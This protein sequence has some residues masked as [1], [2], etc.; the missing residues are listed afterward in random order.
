M[1]T[2]NDRPEISVRIGKQEIPLQSRTAA[3]VGLVARHQAAINSAS[4]VKVVLD[5]S[6]SDVRISYQ[7]ELGRVKVKK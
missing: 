1:S 7:P 5:C 4:T 3:I 2:I 6:P